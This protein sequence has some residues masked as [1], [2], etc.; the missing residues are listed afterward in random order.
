MTTTP[1]P[2]WLRLTVRRLHSLTQGS[3]TTLQIAYEMQEAGMIHC[4]TDGEDVEADNEYVRDHFD[5]DR[6]ES[7]LRAAGCSND[8]DGWVAL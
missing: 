8:G 3:T 1:S 7:R 5:R 4:P 6:L 2:E